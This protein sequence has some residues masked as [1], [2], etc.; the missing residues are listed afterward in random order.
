LDEG[1]EIVVEAGYAYIEDKDASELNVGDVALAEW[2][3]LQP[4]AVTG[5][6]LAYLPWGGFESAIRW[7]GEKLTV[8]LGKVV[9][10]PVARPGWVRVG[11]EL[12]RAT[13]GPQVASGL[14]PGTLVE[15]EVMRNELLW[16]S[17]DWDLGGRG[18]L[19]K[20]DEALGL[21]VMELLRTQR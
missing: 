21:R 18:E 20:I 2:C 15:L 3:G 16:L 5:A 6:A 1:V 17:F 13:L 12:G 14:L 19:V 8:A 9:G 10:P 7:H 4:K 11:F